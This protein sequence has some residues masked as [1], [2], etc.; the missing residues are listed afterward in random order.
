M[1]FQDLTTLANVKQWLGIVA[2]TDDALL[3]RLITAES[4]VIQTWLDRQINSQ[5]YSETRNGSGAGRGMYEMLFANT[6]VTAVISVTVDGRSIPASTDNGVLQPGYG[7]DQNRVWLAQVGSLSD[8]Q[9]DNQYFF[10]R[11]NGNVLLSYTAGYA[12]VPLDIEQA[13]IELISLRY[14]E[15]DRIG[16]A[17]KSMA[18]ETTAFITKAMTDSVLQSIK[19]YKKVVPI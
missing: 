3:T 13:C 5:A 2:T 7:F 8:V 17:S 15:R 6:P 12:T 1:A 14:R 16:Q 9:F 19:Q 10:T 4:M 11:G 18:G